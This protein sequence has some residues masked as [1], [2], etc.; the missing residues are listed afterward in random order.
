MAKP[1]IVTRAGKGSKL[2][3]GEGDANF[4]NL[5]NATFSISDG[6]NTINNDLNSILNLVAGSG[7]SLALDDV[8]KTLTLSTS[9]TSV[10]RQSVQNN[11]GL[12]ILKGKAVYISGANGNNPLIT[13]ASNVGESSSSK[14]FGLVVADIAQGGSGY[15]V[16]DGLLE[17]LDTSTAVI[18]NP[19]WLGTGGNLLYG[20]ANKP[21]APAHL[22]Y[23]G[24]VVRVNQNNGAILVK[25][26]NGYE[27]E[28]L[29]NVS[30]TTPANGDVLIYNST[31]GLWTPG[32]Q[33]G[34][35]GTATVG[36][37]SMFLLMG[38]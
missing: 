36:L 13:L 24:V 1:V 18:G 11:T 21:T 3:W 34:G 35:G 37:D 5:Q 23:L 9:S 17:G 25:V 6:T 28:E 15:V 4:T 16:T 32:A 26:Q 20:L 38:G 12:T 7:V 14:T 33:S 27:I 31:T 10:I 22:V 19:V 30:S 2:T 8:T 29:H